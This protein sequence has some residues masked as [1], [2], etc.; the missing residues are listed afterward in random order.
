M[1]ELSGNVLLVEDDQRY[2]ERLKRNL[3]LEGYQVTAALDGHEALTLLENRSFDLVL[4]DLKMPGMDG[5]DL[6]RAMKSGEGTG[7]DPEVPVLVLTSVKS[8]NSAVEAMRLG[9]EDYVTKDC[10]RDEILLRIRRAMEGRRMVTENRVL[11]ERLQKQ[12]E[13]GDVIAA[14]APMQAVLHEVEEVAS[15]EATVLVT[16]ETGVGKELISR[17][18]H[19]NSPRKQYPFIEVN[20]GALPNDNMFQSELFGHEKG[21][22][23]GAETMRKG[24]FELAHRGTLFLDEIGDLSPDSQRKLLR[25]LELREFERLG[26]TKRIRVDVR[27]VLATNRNL[28]E[29]AD[30]GDFRKDLFYRINVYHIHIPPLRE[31]R[32][33][34]APQAGYYLSFFAEKY[35]R[36]AREFSP[37]ALKALEQCDW[38]GNTRELRIICERLA[39]RVSGSRVELEHL[40]LS[41]L[42][43]SEATTGRLV[44]LPSGGAG[45]DEIERE[46]IIQ[47][48]ERTDWVQK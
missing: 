30:Q 3:E 7:V 37:E 8:I 36:T 32:D 34:I 23:T 46:A 48:L 31:R 21:A 42:G 47:A 45:L 27:F 26:G 4:T 6:L 14:S 12:S 40:A 18:I 33:D 11:R 28:K 39:I 35:G 22:F 16:G 9:A 25:A 5:L 2:A 43:E 10:E 17:A 15:T 20:C 44:S 41:G 13:F 19:D 38:P 24:R 29:M 1:T